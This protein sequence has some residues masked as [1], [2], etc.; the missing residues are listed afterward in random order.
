MSGNYSK[1]LNESRKAKT[2]A[3]SINNVFFMVL[4]SAR[5]AEMFLYMNQLDSALYYGHMADDLAHKF[6]G[7][8]NH[9]SQHALGQ[10][11]FKKGNDELALKYLHEASQSSRNNFLTYN[12]CLISMG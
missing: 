6:W 1:A 7:N 5:M 8:G 12:S 10:I 4:A 2:F 9:F 11:Y 3:D